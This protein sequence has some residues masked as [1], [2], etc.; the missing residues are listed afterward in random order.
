MKPGHMQ[1]RQFCEYHW[2]AFCC[3]CQ[4]ECS[5]VSLRDVDRTLQVMM[6]FYEHYE[7]FEQMNAKAA[8]EADAEVDEEQVVA[9]LEVVVH[10]VML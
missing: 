7:L 3:D 1:C 5:F 8:A 9:P 4:D 2:L 6:W 10:F